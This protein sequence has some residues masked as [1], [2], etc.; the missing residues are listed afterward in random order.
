MD[1]AGQGAVTLHIA[2]ETEAQRGPGTLTEVGCVQY[3]GHPLSYPGLVCPSRS[4]F[5]DP[6]SV[7]PFN[8]VASL[9]PTLQA[10]VL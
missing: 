9:C 7:F 8:S 10:G 2:E 1:K 3:L 6:A 4:T 5:R